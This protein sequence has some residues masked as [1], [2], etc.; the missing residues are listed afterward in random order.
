[1]TAHMRQLGYVGERRGGERRRM[2]DR[3]IGEG[4]EA[5]HIEIWVKDS[6]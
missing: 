3:Y 5:G 2:R 1:M 6:E 4:R